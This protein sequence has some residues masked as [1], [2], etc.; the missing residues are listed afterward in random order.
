MF[1]FDYLK[2]GFLPSLRV[3]FKPGRDGHQSKWY[4]ILGGHLLFFIYWLLIE[5]LIFISMEVYIIGSLPLSSKG[6]CLLLCPCL[7]SGN[8]STPFAI[9]ANEEFGDFHLHLNENDSFSE[10][11][12]SADDLATDSNIG[13]NVRFAELSEEEIAEL[14]LN[15]SAA[16]TKKST[17]MAVRVFKDFLVGRNFD[18]NFENTPIAELALNLR[19]FYC[20]ARK[21][22][23]TLYSN[24]TLTCIR[25]G[26]NRH[27]K[28]IGSSTD[29][30]TSPTFANANSVFLAQKALNK[31]E[32]KGS[33]HSHPPIEESDLKRL[34]DP[35]PENKVFDQ[36]SAAGLQRKVFFELSFYIC[37]RGRENMRVLTREHFTISSDTTGRYLHQ[38]KDEFLKNHREDDSKMQEGGRMY[39]TGGANCPV[40]SYECYISK[41][42]PLCPFLFQRAKRVIR[43]DSKVWYDNA[44]IGVNYLGKMMASISEIASLSTRYTNHSIRATCVT[45]L[46]K[47][48]FDARHIMAISKHKSESSIRS[49]SHK[50]TGERKRDMAT[51]LTGY[52]HEGQPGKVA[53][54]VTHHKTSVQIEDE[55]VASQEIFSQVSVNLSDSQEQVVEEAL[56]VISKDVTPKDRT[57]VPFD[58][59]HSG[60]SFAPVMNNCNVTINY[61]VYNK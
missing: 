3:C 58:S 15:R 13:P 2:P 38:V 6:H 29:I 37:R 8:R 31:K 18:I 12:M 50:V 22:D 16:S 35:V 30:V 26:I 36:S 1:E 4:D 51:A 43:E 34:Y 44:A 14:L 32:G 21:K 20:C 49:Y 5:A 47:S 17:Q 33:T 41:L 7:W 23:G 55:E 61:N 45:L 59:N 57:V 25:A 54:V 42:N 28:D 10:S 19:S 53:K 40:A 11:V 60:G 24:A 46:D 56:S 9:M 39:A 27:L 52:L 48:N